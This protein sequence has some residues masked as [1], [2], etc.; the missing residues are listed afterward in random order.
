MA[1]AK[2]KAK[3]RRKVSA[4]RMVETHDSG[5]SKALRIPS[6]YK[7][8]NI[9]KAGTY[10]W[11]FLPYEVKVAN[12]PH[13]DKGSLHME[14][15]YFVH[16]GIGVNEDTYLCAAKTFGHPCPICEERARLARDPNADDDKVKALKP[17]ERQLW[18]IIDLD[19]KEKEI[20]IFDYSEWLFG[21]YLREKVDKQDPS[22]HYDMF[23]DLE[24]GQTVKIGAREEKNQ[25][26]TWYDCANIEF[27]ARAKQYD[28][29]MLEKVPDL[30]AC[31]Y[32]TPY[33]KLKAIFMGEEG[34]VEEETA[35]DK[36][37]EE[38]EAP[39]PKGNKGKPAPKK[40]EK[41]PEPEEKEEEEEEAADDDDVPFKKGDK[42]EFEYKGDEKTGT[43]VEFDKK[44]ELVRVQCE[45]RTNPYNVEPGDCKLVEEEEPEPEKPAKKGAKEEAPAAKADIKIGAMVTHKEFGICEIIRIKDGVLTLEDDNGEL[46]NGVKP[47]DVKTKSKK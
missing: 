24:E 3:E 33:E 4:K 11:D 22:D 7:M 20:E 46:H 5:G 14:R 1:S 28:E 39:A 2:E 13:A 6:G 42:V 16:R 15:T 32:E 17:K 34:E 8:R 25:G 37:E 30:D 18:I 40:E 31:L 19:S 10:R 9:K 36:P 47:T 44:N 38:E 23:A 45:D 29:S 27:K 12:N 26:T 43:V 35:P 21:R 41:E